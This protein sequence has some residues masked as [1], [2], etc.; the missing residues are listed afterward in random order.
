MKRFDHI[1]FLRAVAII[2]IIITHILSY[3]LGTTLT[4]TVWNYLHFVVPLFVFCSGY[5]AYGKPMDYKKRTVRLLAPFLIWTT[6][7][8]VLGLGL[9]LDYSWLPI[10]FLELMIVTPIY[11]SLWKSHR[12]YL[13]LAIFIS[14]LLK[15][16][17]DYRLY[18]WL[19]WSSILLLSF[20]AREKRI[21]PI[22]PAL[23]GFSIFMIGNWLLSI[24][25]QPLTLTL[26]KYPPDIFYLSYG[27]MIGS[28]LLLIT[29]K[30]IS[31]IVRWFSIHSYNI[32]FAHYIILGLI[33][34]ATAA[35][36]HF[37]Q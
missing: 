4:N 7:H 26:H 10:L 30:K 8:W 22:I 9:R 31:P 25:H 16:P 35:F 20:F 1:D 33:I 15:P 28:I 11:M 32:F 19:P 12:L 27:V 14:T 18:M 24:L 29:P 6:L 2:G 3:N 17:I 23:V 36:F 34:K 37:F 13:V 5:V 21:N